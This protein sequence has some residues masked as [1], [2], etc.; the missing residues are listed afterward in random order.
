MLPE[1]GR[2]GPEILDAILPV[3][4]ETIDR[5]ETFVALVQ[6]WQPAENLIAPSTLPF[7]W[8]RHVADSV[9]LVALFPLIL[10]WVDLG[11]G[12]GFPGVVLACLLAETSA[13]KSTWWKAMPGSVRFSGKPFGRRV[14]RP[15]STRDGSKMS[16]PRG[17]RGLRW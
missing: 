2:D 13:P 11:S 1:T 14:R 8:R 9:Q 5:L 15:L 17:T 12:A 10:R 16:W 3:S 7:I 6:K 4:R